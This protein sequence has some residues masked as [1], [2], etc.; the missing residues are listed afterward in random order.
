MHWTELTLDLLY[1]AGGV[2]IICAVGFFLAWLFWRLLRVKPDRSHA[3]VLENKGNCRS[4]YYLEVKSPEPSLHFSLLVGGSPLAAVYLPAELDSS[5][6]APVSQNASESAGQADKTSATAAGAETVTKA[7]QSASAGAGKFASVL[8]QVGQLL[9]GSLGSR[10]K[11]QSGQIRSVQ[12]KA[13]RV[14]RT[15]QKIRRQVTGFNQLKTGNKNL[16][17][18]HPSAAAQKTGQPPEPVSPDGTGAAYF[19][20]TPVMEAGQSLHLVLKVSPRRRAYKAG[21]YPYTLTALPVPVDFPDLISKSQVQNGTVIFKRIEAWR[22]LL[23][24]LMISAVS[25]LSVAALLFLY[26]FIWL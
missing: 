12:V 8:E 7:G 17:A 18:S 3:V 25:L 9:P 14:A 13:N 6:E 19:V 15:P 22:F 5:P 1:S 2:L 26:R 23:P 21:T 24:V 10:L 20:Q 16:A 11:Q 4:M